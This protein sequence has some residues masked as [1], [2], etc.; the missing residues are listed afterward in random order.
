MHVPGH[1]NEQLDGLRGYAALAVVYFHSI[2]GFDPAL[3]GRVLY[4]SYSQISGTSD[5][6]AK[7]GLVLLNGETAVVIFFIMS[8]AVLFETL[9][10]D[11]GPITKTMK[12]FFVRRFFR[13]YPAL[14][15]CVIA[16]WLA[17]NA[18]SMPR[19]FA[20]LS[21]NL[22]LYEFHVNGATWTLAVEAW[23]AILLALGFV[24]YKRFREAGM[25]AVALIFA[26]LYLPPLNG[27]LL[28]FRMFIYCFTMGALISTPLGKAVIGKIPAAMWPV[29][30]IGTLVARHTIQETLAA[31]LIGMIYYRKS[32]AFGEFL[33]R[34]TSTFLGHISYS[35]YLFNVLFLEIIND[36]LHGIPDLSLHPLAV[37]VITGTIIA[38]MTIPVAYLSVR[39][40]ELPF[41]RLGRRLTTSPT[42][43]FIAS[44]TFPAVARDPA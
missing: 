20:D 33:A 24:A 26:C 40:I 13:I 35:L 11:A 36:R 32:G 29:L 39:L 38:A 27:Y 21:K 8:G 34:P 1:R 25:I 23:G 16:C 41:I 19:S 5:W 31:L 30:L 37:G 17:F 9:Q 42:R 7:I 10:R 14:F 6:I 2:L 18:A 3:I 28:Q 12:R 15:V 4:K 22:A 44:H 43:Q